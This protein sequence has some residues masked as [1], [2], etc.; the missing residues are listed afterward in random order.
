[1]EDLILM[2]N[3]LGVLFIGEFM[4]N[5]FF[6]ERA[7]ALKLFF[8][9]NIFLLILQIILELKISRNL[10]GVIFLNFIYINKL[11]I[12]ILQSFHD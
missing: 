11:L 5:I 6:F 1:M 2:L 4:D 8:E 7:T 9:Q 10:A 3:F 12:L